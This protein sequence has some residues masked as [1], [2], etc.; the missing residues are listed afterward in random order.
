[1]KFEYLNL[2]VVLPVDASAIFKKKFR[3][4]KKKDS[5]QIHQKPH[6]SVQL[7]FSSVHPSIHPGHHT[8]MQP[9]HT[10]RKFRA[11]SDSPIMNWTS[12]PFFSFH[13]GPEPVV[14]SR[15]ILCSC[16]EEMASIHQSCCQSQTS[17]S[18]S[19]DP[20]SVGWLRL[21]IPVPS[22]FC[23]SIRNCLFTFAGFFFFCSASAHMKIGCE[24]TVVRMVSS[25]KF[26]NRVS[27]NYR[28]LDNQE[29]Q[30]IKLNNVEDFCFN[31]W[32]FQNWKHVVNKCVELNW[33]EQTVSWQYPRGC[34]VQKLDIKHRYLELY[35]T[36]LI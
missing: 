4:K 11:T 3:S 27:F 28:L 14:Q 22:C 24:N 15:E 7:L 17:A 1:M 20:V 25:G 23:A 36:F 6:V 12:S 13:S 5:C 29:L 35:H 19:P 34:R 31:N 30:T 9:V 8:L 18:P 32:S 33:F 10:Y 21:L 16:W 2:I 26:V